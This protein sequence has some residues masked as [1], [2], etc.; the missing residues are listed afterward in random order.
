MA[1]CVSVCRGETRRSDLAMPRRVIHS[2]VWYISPTVATS[3][4]DI[5]TLL[6]LHGCFQRSIVAMKPR[7]AHRHWTGPSPTRCDPSRAS[8]VQSSTGTGDYQTTTMEL[9]YHAP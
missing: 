4:L 6:L 7:F 9:E 8:W 2:R 3:S 1:N 5:S